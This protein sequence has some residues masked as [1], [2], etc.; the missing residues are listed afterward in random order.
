MKKSLFLSLLA[1][2]SCFAAFGQK[3]PPQSV[4]NSFSQQFPGVTKVDWS[5]EKNGEWEAEFRAADG[6][7]TSAN[8]SPDGTWLETEMEIAVSDLPAAV[9]DAA[10]KL[11]PGKKIKEAARVTRAS[12]QTLYEVEIG[13]KDVLFDAAGKLVR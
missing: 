1:L 3:N 8:F 10:L 6:R 5:R 4:T 13:S 12:G 2:T 11:Y 9:R 7:E